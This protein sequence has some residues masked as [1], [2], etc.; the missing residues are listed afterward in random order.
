MKEYFRRPLFFLLLFIKLIT[1]LSVVAQSTVAI[2]N[3]GSSNTDQAII[4]NS[5]RYD[6][7]PDQLLSVDA[8]LSGTPEEVVQRQLNA[9]N[10]RDIDAFLATYSD[11]VEVCNFPNQLSMKGKEE[12]RVTY[13]GLFERAPN[14]HAEIKNRIVI[15]NKVI[16]EECVRAGERF[17]S[18]VA[19]Y[20]VADGK[21][22][23][24]TFVRG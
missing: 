4:N 6:V 7:K 19:I 20:E 22:I 11:S 17:F 23:R 2:Q 24:V 1:G 12:M 13:T 18:A 10:A 16:D 9:Y 14:L 15:G 21:I 8:L 3:I 5:E